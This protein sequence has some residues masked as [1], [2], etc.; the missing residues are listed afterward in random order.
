MAEMRESLEEMEVPSGGIT[1]FVMTDEELDAVYGPDEASVSPGGIGDI[2]EVSARMASMG[3]GGD[4]IIAHLQTGELIIPKAILE[5]DPMLAESLLA[6]MRDKGVENPER[7][8]VGEGSSVNPDTGL[9]EFF[10]KKIFKGIGKAVKGVGKVLKKLAPVILPVVLPMIPGI[11]PILAALG[12]AFTGALGSGIGTLIQGGSFSDALKGAALGFAG[13]AVSGAFTGPTRGFAGIKEAVTQPFTKL[14]GA[15]AGVGGVGGGGVGGGAAPVIDPTSIPKVNFVQNPQAG[16]FAT[17]ASA[18][19]P[20]TATTATAA[21]GAIDS[22]TLGYGAGA[23]PPPVTAPTTPVIDP[24]SIP[25]VSFVQNPQAGFESIGAGKGGFLENVTA[26]F[27]PNDTVS[28]TQGMK[29]AFFP[30]QVMNAAGQLV[31]P[32]VLRQYGPIAA[33]LGSLA[34]ISSNTGYDVPLDTGMTGEQLYESD[35]ARFSLFGNVPDYLNTGSRFDPLRPTTPYFD[36]NSPDAFLDQNS[37]DLG[38]DARFG[39]GMPNYFYESD[40][41]GAYPVITAAEGGEIFPRRYGGI[42]PDEGVPDRD[43]VR[44]MLMPGEFVMTKDAVRGMGD[45]N[46]RRGINNMYGVMRNLERRGKAMA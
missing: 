9:F 46:L 42:M 17:T 11:G 45:G 24:N 6:Y 8:I 22:V 3:R 30:S 25:K 28:F 20:V 37:F 34:G 2:S 41:P 38:P 39:L 4:D 18:G 26:A 31:D 19:A 15:G 36:Q 16:A 29:Q 13:G 32:S 1:D 12:P 43:S 33:G 7:F 10:L 27:N 44:A 23:A 14:S 35:P 21:P 40:R 5:E